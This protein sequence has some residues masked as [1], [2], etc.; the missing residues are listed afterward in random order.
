MSPAAGHGSSNYHFVLR[1]QYEGGSVKAQTVSGAV[2]RSDSTLRQDAIDR[3][4]STFLTKDLMALHF[5]N[6]LPKKGNVCVSG[7]KKDALELEY[8]TSHTVRTSYFNI[9][10][11]PDAR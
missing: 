7:E 4:H 9:C 10:P 6:A 1:I 8:E 2:A 11:V 3:I 5:G